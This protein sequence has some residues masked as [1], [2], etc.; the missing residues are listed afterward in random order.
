MNTLSDELVEKI[1]NSVQDILNKHFTSGGKT[2]IKDMRDRLNFACPYCGD[3]YDNPNAKRGNLFLD[4]LT[5]HC[6]NGGCNKH[7]SFNQMIKDFRSNGE[8]T[9]DERLKI[10]EISKKNSNKHRSHQTSNLKF[11][12]FQKLNEMAIPL[13]DF[14]KFTNTSPVKKGEYGYDFVKSRLLIH[15]LDEF[16]IKYNKL[17]I[18][19]LTPDKQ[20]VFGYQIRFINPTPGFG[21]YATGNLEKIRKLCK[22]P[23]QPINDIDET[24]LLQMNKL[25]LLFN[26]MNINFARDTTVFEGPLDSK[27]MKNSLGLAT[28]NKDTNMF[29]EISTIRYFFDN[30]IAGKTKMMDLLK[31]GKKVFMWKKFISDYNLDKYID[32]EIKEIKDL[33][34]VVKLC[35]KNK[36]NAIKFVNKYFTNNSFDLI[37]V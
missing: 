10:I 28:V 20:K 22:L 2:E 6:F 30:D 14:Y 12:L 13:E 7:V 31:R 29:D 19:N 4:S 34:D 24:D 1:Y 33:N 8:M 17:Y 23:Y 36:L 15:S 32:N 18:L 11:H 3:S 16:A 26:I 9:I 27:F 5:Y 21:K 37:N 35:F 25:S